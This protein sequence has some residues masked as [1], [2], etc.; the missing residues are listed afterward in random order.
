MK[1][2]V[3]TAAAAAVLREGFAT[4]TTFC[5][6]LSLAVVGNDPISKSLSLL[7]SVSVDHMSGDF[8]RGPLCSLDL[9]QMGQRHAARESNE[10]AGVGAAESA[11]NERGVDIGCDG[12]VD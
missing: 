7:P 8:I 11:G 1:R 10:H 2:A 6:V 12:G 9:G 3:Y 5:S 4:T